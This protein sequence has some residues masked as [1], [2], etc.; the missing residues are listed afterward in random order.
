MKVNVY[1]FKAFIT[2]IFKQYKLK[3]NNNL[4]DQTLFIKKKLFFIP[5]W[6]RFR[7]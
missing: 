4:Q 1:I 3:Q 7:Y 6:L 5:P 2:T